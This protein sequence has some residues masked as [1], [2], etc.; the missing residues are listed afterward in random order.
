MDTYGEINDYCDNNHPD[1]LITILEFS[2]VL[3]RAIISDHLFRQL[4][5]SNSRCHIAHCD[6]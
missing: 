3:G 1:R 6:G 4:Q 5:P 2:F